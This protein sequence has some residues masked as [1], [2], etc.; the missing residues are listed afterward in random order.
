MLEAEPDIF[1]EIL[2]QELLGVGAA[3]FTTSSRGAERLRSARSPSL[4]RSRLALEIDVARRLRKSRRGRDLPG[5]DFSTPCSRKRAAPLRD[6][7]RALIAEARAPC[8]SR[9]EGNVRAGGVLDRGPQP[10]S[11]PVAP[12]IRAAGSFASI[13]LTLTACDGSMVNWWRSAGNQPKTRG[14]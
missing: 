8:V 12:H 4:S 1:A 9:R 14:I 5:G 7:R 6:L 3:T 11:F 2:A 10:C 13:D